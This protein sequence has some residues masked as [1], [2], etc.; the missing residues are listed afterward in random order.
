MKMINSKPVICV[1]GDT[2]YTST[3][4]GAL[5]EIRTPLTYS[6]AVY[7]GGGVPVIAPELCPEE[8]SELCDGLLLSG[9]ADVDPDLYGEEKLNDTVNTDPIRS[10]FEVPLIKAFVAKKKPI[11]SICRGT[12]MMN[13]VL[14][15]SLHQDLVEE[16]GYVH[17]NG[18]I[19]HYVYAE[20]GSILANLFGEKFKTNST[21][22]QAIKTPA[23]GFKITAHSIEGIVEA[24]EHE[25]LPIFGTQ[26]HPERLTDKY[27]DGRT[28]DF[29]PLFKYFINVVR[30]DAE[31]RS[32]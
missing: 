30:E 7:V 24:Y 25:S 13:V 29:A 16:F 31:K 23:P 28:P 3:E 22:H 15:G 5:R 11:M 20:P 4:P 1:T 27:N 17:M 2:C 6:Q 19:R 8:L 10:Q 32:K 18:K 21:H 14:G 9:G 12:Q 26:F